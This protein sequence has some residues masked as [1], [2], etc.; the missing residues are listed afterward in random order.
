MTIVRS[1][2][3]RRRG[4]NKPR[5]AIEYS[6]IGGAVARSARICQSENILYRISRFRSAHKLSARF[7]P[8]PFT[9]WYDALET[10]IGIIEPVPS[11]PT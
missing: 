10:R 6:S 9:P 4:K 5:R 11:E 2:L 1:K 8:P 7:H 3:S